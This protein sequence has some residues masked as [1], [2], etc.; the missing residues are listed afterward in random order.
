MLKV[1][2]LTIIV[3]VLCTITIGR[4]VSELN[5]R[6]IDCSFISA[7]NANL[8]CNIS[9]T[10]HDCVTNIFSKDGF[11]SNVKDL[12]EG[13]ISEYNSPFETCVPDDMDLKT[14]DGD[15]GCCVWSPQTGCNFVRARGVP[16]TWSFLGCMA[17]ISPERTKDMILPS[18]CPCN[19]SN[20]G[21]TRNP[22]RGK[23]LMYSIIIYF[24][25]GVKY[26]RYYSN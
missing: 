22:E 3:F 20:G 5:S 21:S 11:E 1:Y 18:H 13:S 14:G 9:T 19:E 4:Q 24:A 10:G 7:L 17:C 26:L 23:R 16:E 2:I 6:C 15:F 25:L 8:S 12:Y